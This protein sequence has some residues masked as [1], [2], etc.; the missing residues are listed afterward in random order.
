MTAFSFL[1]LSLTLATSALAVDVD[2]SDRDRFIETLK[3]GALKTSVSAEVDGSEKVVEA[4]RSIRSLD[5]AK[6][7]RIG[8]DCINSVLSQELVNYNSA[9][10]RVSHILTSPE[11]VGHMRYR[12]IIELHFEDPDRKSVV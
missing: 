10:S 4:L 9:G 7:R 5:F 8:S 12:L 6:A 3:S 2:F 11:E 1:A